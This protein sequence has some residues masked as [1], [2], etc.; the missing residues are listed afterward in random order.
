MRRIA[1]IGGGIAGLSAAY[2][3]Q[4]SGKIQVVLLEASNRLGGKIETVREQ[5]CLIELGP[6]SVFSTKPWAGELMTEIGLAEEFIA[7]LTSEFSILSKGKLHPVPRALVGLI[8]TASTALESVGFLST[9]AKRRFLAE[10]DVKP[11]GSEDE[12]IASFF[13]RRLGTRFSQLVAEPLLAGIHG[14]DPTKLSMLAMYPS[15]KGLEQTYG[16]LSAKPHTPATP[17]KAGPPPGFVTLR[18]GLESFV[19][20]LVQCLSSVE[21][22]LSEATRSLLPKSGGLRLEGDGFAGE[23][24]EVILAVP[25]F[26]AAPLLQTCAPRASELLASMRTVSTAAAAFGYPISAFKSPPKGSGFLV[27]FSEPCEITGCTVVSNKWAK[28]APEG[29]VLLRAFMGQEGQPSVDDQDDEDLL[30][31]SQ[32]ALERLVGATGAPLFRRLGRWPRAM[33][34]YEVGHLDL[35]DDIEAGLGDLPIRLVGS[36]YRGNGIP[37]C[38]RQGRAAAQA[39]IDGL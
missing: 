1:V 21:I 34:Q 15:Y 32:N 27:P 19:D 6:D 8:P 29:V 33:T 12:S 38:V 17:G 31:A 14:G 16:S 24:D 20:R 18:G 4:K 2:D 26:A 37:D 39:I 3:L 11:G 7:P 36:A 13:R 30:N 28:R 10:A 22:H 9:A 23:F 35:L 5:G 25:S